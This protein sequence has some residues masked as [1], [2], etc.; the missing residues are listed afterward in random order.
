MIGEMIGDRWLE[1]ELKL[2]KSYDL[3]ETGLGNNRNSH[4]APRLVT[5]KV[6]RQSGME[7]KTL[8]LK[9]SLGKEITGTL[10]RCAPS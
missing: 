5:Y 3:A 9:A 2:K 10:M 8:G 6:R 1:T 4:S 7:T